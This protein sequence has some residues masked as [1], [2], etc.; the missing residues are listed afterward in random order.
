[1]LVS[2]SGHWHL[3]VEYIEGAGAHDEVQSEPP[4]LGDLGQCHYTVCNRVMYSKS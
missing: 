3:F 2:L 4:P 1:V